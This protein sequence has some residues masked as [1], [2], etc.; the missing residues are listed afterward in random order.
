MVVIKLS[1]KVERSGG[2]KDS[3]LYGGLYKE[4]DNYLVNW[5]GADPYANINCF[6]W[7]Q[8]NNDWIVS[9]DK[10]NEELKNWRGPI[11]NGRLRSQTLKEKINIEETCY[12][13][14]ESS[15]FNGITREGSLVY[16]R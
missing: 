10:Y 7:S 9:E 1:E 3:P 16:H 4:E 6:T 12:K 13:Y 11:H 15:K 8:K 2:N 5:S 14:S